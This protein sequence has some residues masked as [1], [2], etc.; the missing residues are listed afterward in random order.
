MSS[1]IRCPQGIFYPQRF[2]KLNVLKD[3]KIKC[4]QGFRN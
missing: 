2:K 4:P 3:L 1:R